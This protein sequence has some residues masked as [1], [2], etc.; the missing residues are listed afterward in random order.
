MGSD[1]AVGI[2]KGYSI[3][4]GVKS[5]TEETSMANSSGLGFQTVLA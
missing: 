2:G 3:D 1:G 4:I 5:G